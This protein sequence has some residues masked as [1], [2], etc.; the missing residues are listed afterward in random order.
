MR[1]LLLLFFSITLFSVHAQHSSD[2]AFLGVTS[3]EIDDDKAEV[4]G[5]PTD[6]GAMIKYVY[7]G[8]AAAAAGLKP[9]DYITGINDE[10]M[11]WNTDLN[12]LLAKHSPGEEVSLKI[13]R[14]GKKMLIPVTL[15]RSSDSS[16]EH[17][18]GSA[19]LGVREHDDNDDD[20]LG[21]RITTV[22]N[23]SAIDLG[24]DDGDVITAINGQP[25]VDWEDISVALNNLEEGDT[26]EVE[27]TRDSSPQR[28]SGSIGG[29]AT[30]SE[31]VRQGR[32]Y[33][34]IYAGHMD[35]NKA[36]KLKLPNPYG[37]YVKRVIPGS[38][39]A[40]AGL[41]PLDYVIG[42][43]DYE[44]NDDRSLIGALSKFSPGDQVRITYI[45]NGQTKTS[46]VTL[47]DTADDDLSP[48]CAEE[49]FFGVSNNHD[50]S[51]R[52]GV[53]VNIVSNS[54]AKE[55]GLKSGD[56]ITSLAG[57][58]IIDWG[59]LSAVINGTK[60]GKEIAI[61]YIRD[62]KN[63]TTTA[64]MGSECDENGKSRNENL[65]YDYNYDQSFEDNPEREMD[66]APAV[67][68][69]RIKVGMEE[70]T[71][72]DAAD[73]AIR[74][75]DMPLVNNLTIENIQLFPNPNRG[76][77]RLEFELPNR[78]ETSIRVFNSEARLIYSFD[79]GEYQG[80]FSDD[81]D[82]SQNGPG[83]YFL[84]IRQGATSMVKK[85]LLQY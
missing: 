66:T 39:A 19:F 30:H 36:N 17:Y 75:V 22:R 44:M 57:K 64:V 42:V 54:A 20:E 81:I 4:L 84:E 50:K 60:V 45:R 49:P 27:Y 46:E 35:N 9:F 16:G 33:L 72:S 34:G 5:L 71:E 80:N 47:G 11:D 1:H 24:L 48:P 32:G 23:S 43:N 10:M 74:G 18:G 25:M 65:W 29:E 41:E 37:S 73:M 13:V 28:A 70:V 56:V 2:R 15:G 51:D 61:T 77:F 14:K 53:P 59:D 40:E 79:L 78:G 21:V 12:D 62:G 8:T 52:Q 7:K 31:E 76:M 68:M 67:D 82:I 6:Q 58:P 63:Q 26:I 69:D 55:A 38:A 85:V 3:T 83:A